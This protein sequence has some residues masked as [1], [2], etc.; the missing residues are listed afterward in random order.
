MKKIQDILKNLKENTEEFSLY[1]SNLNN[2]DVNINETQNFILTEISNDLKSVF[3]NLK[4]LTEAPNSEEVLDKINVIK[5]NRK[6]YL[7]YLM[8]K[9][10]YFK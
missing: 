7:R 2:L 5:S 8:L 10:F 1:M 4:L 6:I 9:Q 3:V